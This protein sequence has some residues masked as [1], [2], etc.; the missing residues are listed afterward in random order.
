MCGLVIICGLGHAFML[1]YM[2]LFNA[3]FVC[4]KF[5]AYVGVVL[6]LDL[7]NCIISFSPVILYC[8]TGVVMVTN[9]MQLCVG[10]EVGLT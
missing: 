3:L 7:C 10:L 6:S 9:A 5:D 1:S 8:S 2:V 4:L